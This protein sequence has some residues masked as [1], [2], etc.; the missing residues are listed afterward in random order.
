VSFRVVL[1][2]CFLFLSQAVFA[3]W[4]TQI[5]SDVLT[6]VNHDSK[7]F[8]LGVKTVMSLEDHSVSTTYEDRLEVF[9]D[10]QDGFIE[11]SDYADPKIK[12]PTTVTRISLNAPHSEDEKKKR[13]LIT[14]WNS[15][16]TRYL[17][18]LFRDTKRIVGN[19]SILGENDQYFRDPQ[20]QNIQFYA[21]AYFQGEQEKVFIHQGNWIEKDP[22]ERLWIASADIDFTLFKLT[23]KNHSG[24]S[25]STSQKYSP[26][27]NVDLLK[28]DLYF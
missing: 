24:G 2:L 3:E 27:L 22:F 11:V 8:R 5:E 23:K 10:P 25:E 16:G 21:S 1:F 13:N 15:D 19:V 7:D 14:Q 12:T 9:F 28:Y 26:K 18:W 20:N 6:Q 4:T 17:A